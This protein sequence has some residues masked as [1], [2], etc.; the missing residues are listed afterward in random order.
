MLV[1][2]GYEGCA[3]REAIN[4]AVS[5]TG[6]NANLARIGF[7]KGLESSV[8]VNPF[9]FG[10]ISHGSMTAA[11]EVILGAVYLDGNMNVTAVKLVMTTL[12]LT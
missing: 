6:N 1:K 4:G 9:R 2:D 3:L 7:E 5:S 12:G 11:V 8:Y 10:P